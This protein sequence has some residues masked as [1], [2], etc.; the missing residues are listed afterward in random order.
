MIRRL[1]VYAVAGVHESGE[2]TSH[3]ISGG[4]SEATNF[5]IDIEGETGLA[6]DF[7]TSKLASFINDIT[8]PDQ[9]I[10]NA[11]LAANLILDVAQGAAGSIPFVGDALSTGYAIEQTLINYELDLAQVEAQREAAVAAVNNPDYNTSAWGSISET[12]RDWVVIEDFQ[13]GIDNILLP[14]VETVSNVGYAI[15][16]ATLN[17]DRGVYIE[18]QIGNENTNLVFIANN[19]GNLSN[20]EFLDD[21]TNLFNGPVISTF[22]QSPID[23][24]PNSTEQIQ[25]EGTYAND[26]LYGKELLNSTFQGNEGSF[27]LIGQFGDD[28]LQGNK[29][30]DHLLGGFNTATPTFAKFT[31]QDDGF[32]ILQGREGDDKLEGGTGNDF[33]D[34]G[35]LIYGESIEITGVITNDGTDTLTG[36]SGNDTFVFN[37][38]STGVDT[39]TDFEVLVDKIQ[40]GSEFGATDNSQ[41]S[42]DNTD[43]GLS[44]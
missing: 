34:G 42:F 38:Q 7:D 16:S 6:L 8:L 33:L 17:G 13:I 43:G 27:Q 18:A 40:I 24:T 14:S 10:E 30:N 28:L 29:G 11:R 3:D 2:E 12:F 5:V 9:D 37:T 32:D 39:I 31:Y 36:G 23:V 41:F 4:D 22:N 44:L 19:Y 15:K 26:H 20:T 35:G 1:G 21:I 25:A